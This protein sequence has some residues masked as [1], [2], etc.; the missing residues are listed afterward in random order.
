MVR[1]NVI[2]KLFCGLS[3]VLL[4]TTV[5]GQVKMAPDPLKVKAK[6]ENMN[7]KVVQPQPGPFQAFMTTPGA[8]INVTYVGFG[9]FPSAEAAFQFAVDIWATQ[10]ASTVPI[11]VIATF[12]SLAPNTL[13]SAGPNYIVR[14]FPGAPLSNTF[15]PA[16]LANSLAGFDIFTDPGDHDIN[17]SFN[18]V[19]A[20]W[21][22][23]TDGNTPSG[24]FDF[25]SVV[26]HELGHGLGFTGSASVNGAVGSLGDPDR[27]Y[28]LFVEN[29]SGTSI[30]SFANPSAA[31]GT[32]LQGDDLFMG[33]ATVVAANGG[34]PAQL[35]AP[36][37]FEPGSSFSHW[38]EDVFPAGNPNSLMTPAIGMAEAIQDPGNLTRALFEDLGWTLGSQMGDPLAIVDMNTTILID[39][40]NTVEN[41]NNGQFNGSGFN[42]GASSGQLDADS[43][44][45]LGMSDGD[46]DFGESGTTGDYARGV[47]SGA[48]S[49]GG[50]Y[51]FESSANNRS[52]GIQPTTGDFTPGDIILQIKNSSGM[53]LTSLDLSYLVYVFNDQGRSNSFNFFYSDDN[54]S[55][56]SIPALD[57]TSPQ[58]S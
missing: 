8:T 49:T 17:A 35:Y 25:V 13:G 32:Q 15:Y 7:T 9:S 4:S 56:T 16:A 30:Q 53:S 41:V 54:S 36:N 1:T 23:G 3:V 33:G 57:V 21:Y 2:V 48:V 52:L 14:D 18:S 51:A 43:W 5:I 29:G 22:F 31:L 27:I 24:Q 11:E 20:N 19:F 28:D 34:S 58:G 26:L 45:L 50:A 47:G 10:I 42:P 37:P 12:E 39:F 40:D 6:F 55:Y 38:D 44:S 46:L